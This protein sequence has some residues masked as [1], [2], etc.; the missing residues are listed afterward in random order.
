MYSVADWKEELTYSGDSTRVHESLLVPA[1]EIEEEAPL[2]IRTLQYDSA[3]DSAQN[4]ISI[5]LNKYIK[6]NS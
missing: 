2:R 4:V 6:Q 1:E 3:N 5:D